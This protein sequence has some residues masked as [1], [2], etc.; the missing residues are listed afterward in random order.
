VPPTW[1][2]TE[3]SVGFE[4]MWAHAANN[5]AEAETIIVI[6]YSLPPTDEFFKT[7]YALGTVGESILQRFWVF[8]PDQSDLI[9]KRFN[10]MLGEAARQKFVLHRAKF[11]ET[12]EKL[13]K[14]VSEL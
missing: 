9:E 11:S 14:L 1:E 3:Y 7:L 4:N 13:T 2:K 12:I 8:D 10:R 5:L 6:G